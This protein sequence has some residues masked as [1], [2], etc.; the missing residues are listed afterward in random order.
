MKI[1][2]VVF[3]IAGTTLKDDAD[4]VANNFTKALQL[5]GLHIENEEMNKVMGYRK[6]DAIKMI[7]EEHN[8]EYTNEQID[9]IHQTFQDLINEHYKT[10]P[11]EEIEGASELFKSLKSE[12]I[13]VALN[14]GFSRSTTNI[15]IDRMGWIEHDLIDMSVTS[16]EVEEGR[17]FPFMIKSIMNEFGITDSKEVAKVGDTPS[18]LLEGRNADCGLN[19]GVLYGTHTK[20][21]LEAFPHHYLIKDISEV[22]SLVLE[23]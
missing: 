18:D 12:G 1:K 4:V 23:H 17:P 2:L 15:I 20:E 10:S 3:D 22:K 19:I 14:T 11:I 16:D 13:K 7:L 8:I 5:G 21:E 6:I 9:Q